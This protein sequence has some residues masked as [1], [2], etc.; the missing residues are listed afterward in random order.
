[1]TNPFGFSDFLCSILGAVFIFA[2]LVGGAV[3][4][5][6]VEKTL[7]Y[8]KTLVLCSL[9]SLFSYIFLF[10]SLNTQSGI[11]ILGVIVFIYG[12]TVIPVLPLGLDF[13]CELVFPIGEALSSGILISAS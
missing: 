9:F 11:L 4:G 6:Y 1:L 13:G 12:F 2:G 10:V 5:I 3:T 7:K 8:K